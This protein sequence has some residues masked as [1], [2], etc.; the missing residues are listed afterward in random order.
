MENSVNFFFCITSPIPMFVI[1]FIIFFCLLRLIYNLSKEKNRQIFFVTRGS[2]EA[3]K[4]F[5]TFS[6][7]ICKSH[8][9]FEKVWWNPSYF[10]LQNS[11]QS[12]ASELR[13]HPFDEHMPNDEQHIINQCRSN[14]KSSVKNDYLRLA[15]AIDR[16]AFIF[17]LLLFTIFAI[18][19]SIWFISL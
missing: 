19:Y 11:E 2:D 18:A 15:T 17:Y 12:R 14:G 13:E 9:Q 10:L 6:N 4:T 7:Y 16:I 8:M 1:L 3:L 5:C